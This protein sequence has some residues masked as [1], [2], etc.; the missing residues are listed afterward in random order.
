M[1]TDGSPAHPADNYYNPFGV[2]L[3]VDVRRRLVEAGNRRTEQEVDLWRAL[4]GLEGSVDRWT[5]EVALQG[6]KA[7]ATGVEKG[8]VALSRLV[9][10]L[11]PSGLDDSGRIVCGSPDPA[12]GRVP[13]ASIIPDCVPL[14]LFGGAGSITEEQLAY[15]MPGAADQSR[16]ERAAIRGVRP[17]RPGWA[18][19]G[20]GRAVGAGCRLPARSRQPGA[21]SASC[22]LRRR[23]VQLSPDLFRSTPEVSG[24]YDAHELFAAVQVPLLHDRRWARDMALNI[25]LRW[26]D[27]SSFDQ[28]TTWQAGLRW[29]PAE[30]LTLRA[31][32]SEVFRAPSLAELYERP[33]YVE[34]F[35]LDPCGNDPTPTQRANCAA[36]G[37]P[38]GAYVQ[39]GWGV[40]A[41]YGGNPELEPETGHTLGAGL[42]YTP[43]WAKGLSASVD[44]FQVN[45]SNY[46]SVASPEEML[47]ECAERG[48]SL[49]EGDHQTCGRPGHS[50]GDSL[51][52]LRGVGRPR[53]RLCD[54]LVG[55]D[56]DRRSEFEAARHLPR[57]L[58]QAAVSR[59]RGVFIR[60]QFR[61]G[62]PAALARVGTPR[63]ALRALD[64][65]LRGRIYRQL[66]GNVSNPG[67]CSTSNSSLSTAASIRFC[68]TTSKR[69]SDSTQA[70]RC[71]RRSPMSLTKTRPTSTSRPPTRMWQP[72]GCL[73]AAT[74]WS[75]VTRSSSSWSILRAGRT[76][77][78]VSWAST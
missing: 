53:L 29:Q 18:D 66:L 7:E 3:P 71:E 39:D 49:C 69:D 59:R 57:S 15:V 67:S 30:E 5:W 17:E 22:C 72:T 23:P 48:S 34:Q 35:A 13:A 36:N 54:Q 40:V 47:F 33:V 78:A 51:P 65:Q 4:I 27:F 10:A 6:A 14:N 1:L 58:G 8:F 70:S 77:R 20:Q 12:T 75:C 62:R 64:G 37:V 46:I 56:P 60:G 32:Y 68:I 73:V 24:A 63:L 44:Y 26:S 25:G 43:V 38:G 41:V 55:N 31:N 9:P 11:G 50:V 16:H 42:I 61:C 2:D 45:Q 21:G 52:Q 19:A 28:H 74:S 76:A